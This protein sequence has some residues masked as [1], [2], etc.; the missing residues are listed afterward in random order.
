MSTHILQQLA[1]PFAPKYVTWKPG[2]TTKDKSKCLAMAYADPRAYQ[3][4]LDE[5]FDMG[6]SVSFEPWGDR[7]ICHLTIG[8]ATRSSTGESNDAKD[9]NAGT[10][11]EAQA[12]KRACVMFGLGRYL[13]ELPTTWVGYDSKARSISGTGEAE[14]KRR[15]AS[16]HAIMAERRAKEEEPA[17]E[18]EGGE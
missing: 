13:Y 11:A 18:M 3:N 4:R 7:I 2:A 9:N 10:I 15:Y 1:Q 5:I 8:E 16:Y 14:L 6:W 12:F 17:P